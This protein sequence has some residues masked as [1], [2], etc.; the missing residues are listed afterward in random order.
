M[1]KDHHSD[2]K[3]PAVFTYIEALGYDGAAAMSDQ[4]NG[5]AAKILAQY[6]HAPYI[7]CCNHSLNLVV[8]DSCSI[9]AVRNCL[10]TINAIIAFFR[11][12]A[13]RQNILNEAV[14]E[15]SY[16]TKKNA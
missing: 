3:Q 8:N 6:A 1:N 2:H 12:S 4:F 9:P 14:N 16:E 11:R 13:Q 10:S 7:H 15:L 5:C